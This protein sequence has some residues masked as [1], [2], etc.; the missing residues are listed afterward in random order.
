MPSFPP[1]SDPVLA[2]F[3]SRSAQ[4]LTAYTSQF[5]PSAPSPTQA[6][7]DSFDYPQHPQARSAQQ[8]SPNTNS[9]A[10]G[11]T[12]ETDQLGTAN[13]SYPSRMHNKEVY[14]GADTPANE[15]GAMGYSDTPR[16]YGDAEADKRAKRRKWLFIGIPAVLVIAAA[17]AVGVYFGTRKN[18]SSSNGDGGTGSSGSGAGGSSGG[19][20]GSGTGTGA[21]G[22]GAN[23]DLSQFGVKSSG[24]DGSTVT[25]DTGATFTYN[26]PFGGSWAQDPYNPYSVRVYP[27]SLSCSGVV[28]DYQRSN[29]YIRR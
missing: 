21:G 24:T 4:R 2:H 22:N 5:D 8:Y 15:I 20:A 11:Q 29:P 18:G 7:L 16:D 19:G 3:Q 14:E 27:S 25:T 1:S 10:F 28:Y 9:P 17:I 13:Y 23:A 26:N 12:G 6:Y